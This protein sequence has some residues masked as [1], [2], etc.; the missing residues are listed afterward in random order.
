MTTS[1]QPLVQD[2]S[3]FLKEYGF[4]ETDLKKAGLTWDFLL[5]IRQKYLPL[6]EN[7]QLTADFV[8]RGLQ[9]LHEVH[10]LK[11]RIKHPDHLLSKIVRRFLECKDFIVSPDDFR[12]KITDLIGIRAMHLF[13]DQWKPIHDHIMA[14]WECEGKP[15]AS[16]RQ[17]DPQEL[18]NQFSEAG[19]ELR[20]HPV[21]YRS[22]HY[23][24][25]FQPAKCLHLVELQVR[26]VFEEGWS[27][28]DHIIRYPRV[29]SDPYLTEFLTIFNRLA[30]SADEMGT[31][32]KGLSTRLV[33]YQAQL[34]EQKRQIERQEK[35]L[36]E[37]ISKLKI[38]EAEK[39]NLHEK[40]QGVTV[41]G[42]SK[43]PLGLTLGR[44]QS[45][46]DSIISTSPLATFS[47]PLYP[48]SISTSKT[49]SKCG[50]SYSDSSA[51]VLNFDNL[52]PRCR[53]MRS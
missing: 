47:S 15:L 13:K 22:I 37:T 26:T 3:E 39:K 17:G 29:S 9:K 33:E 14:T 50:Q 7:F 31:F 25:K 10:S 32:I 4:D 49:C 48:V 30:G 53:L 11:V 41:L 45:L 16:Y 12:E 6:C 18:L 19:C 23:T 28:I 1:T 35:D 8:S 36:S 38:S 5:S 51:S 24:I 42:A 34:A 40:V 2:L 20:Q 21:G 43:T 46:L 52:C 27:E 44:T